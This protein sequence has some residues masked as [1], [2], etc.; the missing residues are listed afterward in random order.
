MEADMEAIFVIV[1]V[2]CFVLCS[3]DGW[4]DWFIPEAHCI[5]A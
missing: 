2:G 1:V 5:L 4:Y 3:L